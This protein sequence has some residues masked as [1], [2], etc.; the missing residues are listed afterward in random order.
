MTNDLYPQETTF[1]AAYLETANAS[2]SYRRCNPKAKKWKA[3]AVHVAASRML[4][5]ANVQLRLGVLQAKVE[6][7]GLLSLEEHMEE[8]RKL[9]ELAK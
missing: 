8:L 5:R 1:V 3:E 2:E 9:R 4:S 7:K 6:A